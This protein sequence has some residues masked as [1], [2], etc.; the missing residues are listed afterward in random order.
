MNGDLYLSKPPFLYWAG[1]VSAAV[2]ARLSEWSVRLPSALAATLC[3]IGT[4]LYG[5]RQAGCQV[6][7]FAVVFL[8]A[9]GAFSLFARRSEIEM[10]LTLRCFGA[11]LA[12]WQFIFQQG[13]A[14]WNR[15]SYVL[16]VCALLTKGPGACCG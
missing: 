9:N 11:L 5:I 3:C 6:G 13:R 10:H 4:Y 8:A 12:A 2:V 1:L 7:L 14:A 15:F 16:V